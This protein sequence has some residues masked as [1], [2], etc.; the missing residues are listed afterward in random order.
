MYRDKFSYITDVEGQAGPMI[1]LSRL[2]VKVQKSVILV[3]QI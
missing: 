1:A 3:R 2:T